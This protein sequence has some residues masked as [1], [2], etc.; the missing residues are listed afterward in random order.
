MPIGKAYQKAL[1]DLSCDSHIDD[2]HVPDIAR[3]EIDTSKH[4]VN[5][6]IQISKY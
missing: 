3:C 5:F 2:Y 6:L 4:P 1:R